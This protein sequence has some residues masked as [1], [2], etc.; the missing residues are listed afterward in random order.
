MFDVVIEHGRIVDGTGRPGRAGD[1]GIVGERVVATGRIGE[2]EAGRR[3]DATGLIVAPGFIDPHS[4][5][6]WTVEANRD[7]QSTVRQGVTT[8]VV[9]NCGVSNAPVS[10]RSLA[11][12]E[13]R[14]HL[15]GCEGPPTWSSFGEYLAEIESAGT[16]QNLAWLVGHSTVRAAAGVGARPPTEGQLRAMEDYVAEALEAGAW[17]MSSGLEYGEGRFC[18][19]EELLRLGRVLGEHGGLYA[20]HIRNRDARILA[21]VGEAVTICETSG[22]KGQVSHLNV[23]RNTGASPT[24]WVDAVQLL[25]EARDRGVEMEADMTPFEEGLGLMAGVL[26]GWLLE[27]GPARAAEL[28]AET[29]V[30]DRVRND[31]DR[32]WRFITLGEWHRVRLLHST[33]FPEFDGM[34]FPEIAAARGGDEWDAFFDILAAA[35]PDMTDLTMIGELFAA[36]DLADQLHHP[37]FSCGV[38]AYSDFA[39]RSG[40]L[41]PT[42]LSFKGHVEY[43]AVHCRQ[44][45]TVTLEE[46][47]RKLTDAPAR[48][49]GLQDRGRLEPGCFADVVLFD[50]DTV[51]S[52][53]SFSTPARYPEGI[54]HVLVN[55][56]VVVNNGQH[57][58]G[59]PGRI[60]RPS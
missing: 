4:H 33:E 34:R 7:A 60:L 22:C 39:H 17:G 36:E 49:F 5:T 32:Y 45:R 31:A 8:E 23:R 18:N 50:F 9:G 30:R 27:E 20:S 38:D 52:A 41:A 1:V 46:M 15:Y 25:V 6:D 14:R 3:I 37:L 59:R 19:Q 48:R 29:T 2:A 12:V 53:S 24:A 21:A 42:P 10:R 11:G 16:S 58:A 44:R 35:G 26:P 55:G 13:R 47:V 57:T 56:S 54:S 43:L 40:G 51:S 28:L